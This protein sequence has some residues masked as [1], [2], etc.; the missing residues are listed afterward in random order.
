MSIEHST[1]T[2]A[3]LIAESNSGQILLPNFQRAFVW[4]SDDHR[5]LAASIL[6][7]IPCGSLLMVKGLSSDFASRKVGIAHSEANG[8]E[9]NCE[10]LLDGQQRASTIKAIFSDVFA[11]E[12]DWTVGWQ[13]TFSQ[14]RNRWALRIR[15]GD[16]DPDLFGYR[17]LKY[18]G[19]PPEPD[20][21]G[22]A[23]IPYP[24]YKT[25]GLGN[26]HH[27]AF[28]PKLGP[29][30]RNVAIANV[31]ASEGVVPLWDV[32]SPGKRDSGP[33]RLA[34]AAMAEHR[35]QELFAAFQ[36]GKLLESD[37]PDLVKPGESWE[38]LTEEKAKDRL[39]DRRAE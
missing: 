19:L 13:A 21:V 5:S 15:P 8:P 10:F 31:A 17:A 16:D 14:L 11:G 26:W 22:D 33:I 37:F 34:L 20:L 4:R 23:L 3:A 36:D 25:K 24:V 32:T 12:A 35:R 30:E 29:Q 39:G 18:S 9:A 2:L 38:T 27:P 7:N 1:R 6:L 28:Q